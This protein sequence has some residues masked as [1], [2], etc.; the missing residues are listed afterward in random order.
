MP[1]WKEGCVSMRGEVTLE[2]PKGACIQNI[3]TI[4]RASRDSEGSDNTDPGY[5]KDKAISHLHC[6]R[7]R[8][9]IKPRIPSFTI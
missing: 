8:N 9:K 7:G 1:A 2:Y 6:P 4:C 3:Q 5:P